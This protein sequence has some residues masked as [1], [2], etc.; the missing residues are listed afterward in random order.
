IG[1]TPRLFPIGNSSYN[2][3]TI[4]NGGTRNWTVRVKDIEPND[5]TFLPEQDE[6]VQRSWIINPSLAPTSPPTVTLQYNEATE[7][8]AAFDGV[9][10][11]IM[12]NNAGTWSF[13]GPSQAPT[14]SAGGTR[15]VQLTNFNLWGEFAISDFNASSPGDF[16]RST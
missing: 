2:P 11:G 6:A 16:Y 9:T 15:T 13:T 14:G 10:V 3:V 5:E 8:G 4:N 12:R 1:T 7:K